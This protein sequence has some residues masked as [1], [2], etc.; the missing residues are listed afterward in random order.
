M[1]LG[2]VDNTSDVNKPVSSAV[3]TLLNAKQFIM[4]D[5]TN[6]VMNN[7]EV[8]SNLFLRVKSSNN[9][10]LTNAILFQN[11]GS[12]YYQVTTLWSYNWPF[13]TVD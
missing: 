11:T 5:N 2:S 9:T 6:L 1:G 10:D 13:N 12:F 3:Q 4:T 7:C 8:E